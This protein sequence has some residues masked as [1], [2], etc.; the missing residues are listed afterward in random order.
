[1]SG[2]LNSTVHHDLVKRL[3]IAT[4]AV[5]IVIVA[6]AYYLERSRIV[7]DIT[8][9]ATQRVAQ[10]NPNLYDLLDDPAHLDTDELLARIKG[11]N[12]PI[13]QRTGYF[14]VVAIYDLQG[15][16]IVD[17]IDTGNPDSQALLEGLAEEPLPRMSADGL[18]RKTDPHRRPPGRADRP[19]FE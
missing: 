12:G 14:P 7:N 1:M 9:F 4:A 15:R 6:I 17:S 13:H 16:K 19:A 11:R 5:S 2:K 18:R 10:I 8:F 3:V